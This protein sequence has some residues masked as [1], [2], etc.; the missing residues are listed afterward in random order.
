M[1]L[2][3]AQALVA[4]DLTAGVEV[5]AEVREQMKETIDSVRRLAY[6]LRPP[7]LDQFGLVAAIREHAL[8]HARSQG[9]HQ[10]LGLQVIIDAPEQMPPL[11][12]AVEVA[13]F[14]IAVEAITNVV[15]HAHAQQCRLR[16]SVSDELELEIVDDGTGVPAHVR[17]GV[18]LQSMR[19]R[20]AELGGVCTI[21][22]GPTRGTCVCARL[23]LG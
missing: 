10:G 7:V 20:A 11:P 13:A 19:E 22:A 12:A 1:K 9:L 18:G 4:D 3:V 2:E 17:S 21:E 8:Q 15:R 23:P 6:A 16:L 14:Y 5:L